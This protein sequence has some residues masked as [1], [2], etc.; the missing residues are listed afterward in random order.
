MF[1][2]IVIDKYFEKLP[3]RMLKNELNKLNNIKQ[4]KKRQKKQHALK[5][6]VYIEFPKSWES[7]N[8]IFLFS[9]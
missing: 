1:A 2:I 4:T 3:F 8:N 9:S 6:H 5:S 7:K